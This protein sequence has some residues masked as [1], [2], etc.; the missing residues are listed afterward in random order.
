MR[1]ALVVNGGPAPHPGVVRHLPRVDLCVAVDAG[2]DHAFALGIP[3]DVVVGD[4]DSVSPA[5]LARAEAMD[6]LVERHPA[7]KDATDLE[8]GV[9]AALERGAT[10]VTVVAGD[11]G[12]LDHLLGAIA[13][14]AGDDLD[15]VVVDAFVGNA[16][17]LV[18]RDGDDRE[19]Q[20]R[21]GELVSVF[22]MGGFAEG[23]T[24]EG[25]RYPLHEAILLPGSTLGTSNE[26]ARPTARV[27]VGSGCLLVVQPERLGPA[28]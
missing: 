24:L 5:A 26:F 12:R 20:G 28:T 2:L 13:F 10:D 8:L 17:V 23:V 11:G 14:L 15:E 21:V 1:H 18:L 27:R 16:A 9:R 6:V 7:D 19:V 22:P 3:V 4:L 25:L